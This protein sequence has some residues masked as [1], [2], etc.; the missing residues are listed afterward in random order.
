MISLALRRYSECTGTK[1]APPMIRG[2]GT[3]VSFQE[4]LG[5]VTVVSPPRARLNSLRDSESKKL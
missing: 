5:G 3:P 4:G 1:V 2:Q